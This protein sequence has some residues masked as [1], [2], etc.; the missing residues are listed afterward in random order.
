M[1][2]RPVATLAPKAV[3]YARIG[4]AL[5][6]ASTVMVLWLAV[7]T[8]FYHGIEDFA[9][10]DAFHQSAMLAAGMGPVKDINSVAGKV[11]DSFYALVSGFV[12]LGA[13][14]YLFAPFA[15][16]LLRRYHIEDT[17]AK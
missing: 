15:H 10:I 11:F 16:R 3:H 13:A 12:M 9:W 6:L 17:D 1:A 5:A 4:R 8:F 7:G 14:G 2:Q